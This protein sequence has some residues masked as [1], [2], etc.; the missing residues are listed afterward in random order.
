MH[1]HDHYFKYFFSKS[2]IFYD[3]LLASTH[4]KKA[5]TK[6]LILFYT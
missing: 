2:N 3:E 5:K 1:L 6:V 4:K